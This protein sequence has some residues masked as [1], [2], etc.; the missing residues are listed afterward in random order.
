MFCKFFIP[1]FSVSFATLLAGPTIA[2]ESLNIT[3]KN[4]FYI[5]EQKVFSAQENQAPAQLADLPTTQLQ[6]IDINA[7][8]PELAKNKALTEQLLN[9]AIESGQIGAVKRLLP[10]YET[11]EQTDP[12]LIL[13]AKAKIAK[14]DGDYQASIA[15]FREML[16][17]NPNLTPIRIELAIVLFLDQQD[18]AA[19]EQFNKARS[20]SNVPADIN[21]LIEQ[22]LL[23]LEKRD[24]WQVSL[25]ARYLNEDN[26]N[27]ASSSDRIENTAFI[28]GDSM[29]PQKA[30][31][32][33]YYVG[34][35]RDF[36]LTGSHY[37]HVQNDLF[38]KNYWDNHDYDE[39]TNRTYLGYSHKGARQSWSLLPFY[40]RQ[41]Y[42][43]HRYKWASGVRAEYNR[44]LNTHWQLSGALEYSKNRYFESTMLNGNTKLA[45]LT[46][47]WQRNA[48]QFF[49]VGTDFSR[50][51]TAQRSY[52]YDLKTARVGW[53]QEWGWGISSRINGSISNREYK[54]NLRL[55]SAFRFSKAREDKIYSASITLWKRD[56]HLWGITPK[57]NYTWKKQDSNFD[58]LYS[59]SDKSLN[60][61]FE[62]SF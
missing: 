50:E 32:I 4:P 27:N 13:F 7:L 43:N 38:G 56:W 26:V 12:L 10:I 8:A 34:L 57:L 6:R 54:N 42:G 55:G 5:P 23:A 60:L 53:G 49:Y 1:I 2:S 47:V 14:S 39:I 41:W 62:K 19:K 21:G 33:G 20:D 30:H 22:Y 37:L 46:L 44:W 29:K 61:F 35:E 31:G 17:Q 24:G 40:E 48:K 36:N 59:Y 58:S 18:A 28:K 11:F 9:R 15:Y 3:E 51:T 25:S 16:A 52:S 45:S